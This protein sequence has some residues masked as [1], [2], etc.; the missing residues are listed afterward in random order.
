VFLRAEEPKLSCLLAP[1]QAP[2]YYHRQIMV[3]EEVFLYIFG[4]LILLV[5]SKKAVFN[6][7]YK[8]TRIRSRNSDL[9]L[10]GAGVGAVAERNYFASTTLVSSL[11]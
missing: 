2:F 9:R 4:I 7:S 8:T 1:G 3:A 11:M 6:V 5:K 10:R